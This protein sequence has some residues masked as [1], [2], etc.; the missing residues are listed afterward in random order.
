MSYLIA[1]IPVADETPTNDDQLCGTINVQ[2]TMDWNSG[3]DQASHIA[4]NKQ[5]VLN[6]MGVP[7]D[8]FQEANLSIV[9]LNNDNSEGENHTNGTY[10]AWYDADGNTCYFNDGH[11]Y[12][13]VFHNLWNWNCG[14]YQYNCFDDH[15]TVSMQYQYPHNG[16]LLKVNVD[17]NF[18]ITHNWW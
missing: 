17:V 9:P 3:F 2:T 16:T 13:E 18:T 5:Q 15:H 10:G 11:V 6:L 4:I 8:E 7:A 1:A 12:I 14:L